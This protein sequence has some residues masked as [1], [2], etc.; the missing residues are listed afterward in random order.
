[1]SERVLNAEG[2]SYTITDRI[3]IV[4]SVER[5][6][7]KLVVNCGGSTRSVETQDARVAAE[8]G[9]EWH[10]STGTSFSVQPEDKVRVSFASFDGGAP[11]A[12]FVKNI[13]TGATWWW[14]MSPLLPNFW[15]FYGAL[16]S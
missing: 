11:H 15:W 4:R 3:G 12:V 16:A 5:R 8:D 13:D 14:S 2:C 10:M 6:G 9:T 1:M 7:E